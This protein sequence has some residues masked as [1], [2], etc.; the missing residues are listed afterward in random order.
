M[1]FS[2]LTEFAGCDHFPWGS[3]LAVLL[4]SLFSRLLNMGPL[5]LWE[6][7]L[8]VLEMA[9]IT[10]WTVNYDSCL[11]PPLQQTSLYQKCV[12]PLSSSLFLLTSRWSCGRSRTSFLDSLLNAMQP[13]VGITLLYKRHI[14]TVKTA[15]STDRL[16]CFSQFSGSAGPSSS[17]WVWRRSS[18]V[19]LLSSVPAHWPTTSSIKWAGLYSCLAVRLNIE[20][21]DSSQTDPQK[22]SSEGDYHENIL[23]YVMRFLPHKKKKLYSLLH[24]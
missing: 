21:E 14:V 22:L 20:L 4:H 24:L 5:D 15:Q 13:L 11:F 3:V 7:S 8:H 9:K 10:Q 12:R 17:S 1:L 19:D 23:Q 16:S 2:D 6:P 18:S